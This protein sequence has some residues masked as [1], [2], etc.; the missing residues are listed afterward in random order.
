MDGLGAHGQA[1]GA[2]GE[3]DD[4]GA[5]Q[6]AH[7]GPQDAVEEDAGIVGAPPQYVVRPAGGDRGQGGKRVR[8]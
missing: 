8:I 3:K 5:H 6:Q 4:E 2:H 7:H 1:A